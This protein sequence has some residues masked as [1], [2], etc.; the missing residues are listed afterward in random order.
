MLT[1]IRG[2]YDHGKIILAEE[3]HIHSKTEVIVTFL[4]KENDKNDKKR[5]APGA[6][7]GLVN[8]PD[9]FNEPLDEMKDYM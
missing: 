2:V 5:G 7:K 9:D 6:L 8:M 1:T 3:P 4:T